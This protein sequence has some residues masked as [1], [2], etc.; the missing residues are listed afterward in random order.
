MMSK[1]EEYFSCPVCN[2]GWEIKKDNEN[3][4]GW[5]GTP[6]KSFKLELENSDE[7][8]LL[9]AD[10]EGPYTLVIN[11]INDGLIPIEIGDI[12]VE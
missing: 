3:F 10:M 12:K 8:M 2:S 11:V 1:Q 7:D 6:L 5:C 9:Y 4:C